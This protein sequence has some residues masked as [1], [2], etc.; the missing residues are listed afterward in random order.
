MG[1]VKEEGMDQVFS[2]A[3]SVCWDKVQF[4]ASKTR[5]LCGIAGEFVV[6]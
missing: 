6:N 1:C 4:G 2:M 5:K 3:V